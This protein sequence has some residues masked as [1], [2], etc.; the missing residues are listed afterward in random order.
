MTLF[1]EIKKQASK[2]LL[3]VGI[4]CLA[5]L[6][7]CACN[8]DTCPYEPGTVALWS[9]NNERLSAVITD[10]GDDTST[11]DN[12]RSVVT[13]DLDGSNI[14]HVYGLGSEQYL[15]YYSALKN[16]M[17]FSSYGSSGFGIRQYQRLDLDNLNLETLV[18]SDEACVNRHVVPSLDG[19]VLAIVEVAGQENG[20]YVNNDPEY[21]FIHYQSYF[22]NADS[23][24]GCNKLTMTV[25]LVDVD[26]NETI[27]EFLNEEIN[28]SYSV[29]RTNSMS[30]DLKI[31]WSNQGVIIK[32][33]SQDK[34]YSMFNLDGTKADYD[35]PQDCYPLATSSSY[36]SQQNIEAK[37]FVIL[38][39]GVYSQDNKVE[40]TDLSAKSQEDYSWNDHVPSVGQDIC[41]L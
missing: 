17:I 20:F 33:N 34:I 12:L 39:N 19:S 3:V 13:L 10:Y 36:V 25:T 41:V 8:N 38:D 30:V 27:T 35:F 9:D 24:T 6:Q 2:A 5:L 11:K 29:S 7:G 15:N 23:N 4:L 22:D 14:S 16:Y 31:Y 28:L 18:T 1:R 26:N 21:S 32:S 40:L 37:A